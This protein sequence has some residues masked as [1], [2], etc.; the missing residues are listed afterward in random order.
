[1]DT[2]KVR[3]IATEDRRADTRR[4]VHEFGVY[5]VWHLSLTK[6]DDVALRILINELMGVWMDDFSCGN[7]SCSYCTTQ[8]K[9]QFTFRR[10]FRNLIGRKEHGK[11]G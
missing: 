6:P 3:D 5:C 11:H 10:M 1:M 4:L 9:A 2:A 7:D 8:R